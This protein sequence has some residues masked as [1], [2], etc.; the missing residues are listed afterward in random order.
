MSRVLEEIQTAVHERVLSRPL[1]SE[2]SRR[3][4]VSLR[5]ALTDTKR[6]SADKM[7][8]KNMEQKLQDVMSQFGVRTPLSARCDG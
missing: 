2:T 8:I 5:R 3:V 6:M 1:R 7:Q 4:L